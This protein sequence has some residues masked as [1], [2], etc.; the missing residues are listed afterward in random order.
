LY[1]SREVTSQTK[2]EHGLF[3]A[4]ASSSSS[5]SSSV[6]QVVVLLRVL[7]L[8]LDLVL[9][10][11][12]VLL[13]LLR[14]LVLV[15]EEGA[16]EISLLYLEGTPCDEFGRRDCDASTANI[17]ADER[18]LQ[19]MKRMRTEGTGRYILA[20]YPFVVR[21]SSWSRSIGR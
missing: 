2:K 12:L 20:D 5:S 3:F 7:N 6:A 11:C 10:V 18:I 15:E 1:R 19:I 17:V 9:A 16:I 4:L 21:F 14:A 13:L 8:D